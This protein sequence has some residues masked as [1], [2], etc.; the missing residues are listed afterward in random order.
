MC[1]A[2]FFRKRAKQSNIEVVNFDSLAFKLIKKFNVIEG[3]FKVFGFYKGKNPSEIWDEVLDKVLTSF[4]QQFLIDEYKKVILF[5]NIIELKQYF[6]ISRVGRGK[7]ISRKQRQE[8]WEL[9]E[10]YR[11]LKS[12]YNIYH[13]AELYNLLSDFLENNPTKLYDHIILDEL[14]DFSNVELRLIRKMVEVKRNDLFMVGDPMQKIYKNTI[15]FSKVFINI[16]G[17]KS[18]RLR[19]NYRTTEEIK[20][21]ALSIVKEISFDDF[22]GEEEDK[23]GY[24]SLYRGVN[25]SYNV[26]KTKDKEVDAVLRIYMIISLS[27][28]T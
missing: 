24:V 12:R 15:N 9:F 6:R 17:K 28:L 10:E 2:Y 21:L 8:I 11:S 4:S 23:K 3:S 16:R 7:A 5:N 22:D 14:Q 1:L 27:I 18:S 19:I 25:P 20:K 13:K 26:F